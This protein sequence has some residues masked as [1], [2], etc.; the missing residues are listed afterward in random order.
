MEI[1]RY[2]HPKT[3]LAQRIC[4][5]C[6]EGIEDETHFLNLC[7]QLI[8]ER[9]ALFKTIE[10]VLGSTFYSLLPGE[11]IINTYA[12]WKKPGSGK[13]CIFDGPVSEENHLSVIKTC[14]SLC[15]LSPGVP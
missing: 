12:L 15:S 14:F 3:P 7:L 1:G 9:I 2:R 10:G 6:N 5:L 8:Q 11:D 4:Q 13:G